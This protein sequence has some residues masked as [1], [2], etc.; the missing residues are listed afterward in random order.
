MTN[1]NSA[2]LGQNRYCGP[3]VL[4]ILTGKS[5]DECANVISQI[6]GQYNVT[7]VQ[8]N[9]LMQAADKLGFDQ[10][11]IKTIAGSSLYRTLVQLALI[12]GMY[13]LLIE[14]HYVVVEVKEKKIYLCDNH[15][16]EPIP[17]ESS[18]RLSMKVATAYRV[19]K[20][21][22]IIVP[23]IEPVKLKKYV[24]M[25]FYLKDGYDIN[26]VAEDIK[27]IMLD[28]QP[29]ISPIKDVTY[30]IKEES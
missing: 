11:P 18:S 28:G 13:I 9:H 1:L 3:A 20:R 30:A 24:E 5:S 29:D 21:E 16:K 10:I 6:N 17:A 7:G 8:I 25:K 15:T 14:S 26:K 27:Y 23:K 12:D 4:S 2:K 19:I 22:N